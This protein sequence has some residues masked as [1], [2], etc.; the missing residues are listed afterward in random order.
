MFC[1]S[2]LLDKKSV[3]AL[4]ILLVSLNLPC[5]AWQEAKETTEP[6][7]RVSKLNTDNAA[8]KET[9]AS[10]NP[11]PLADTGAPVEKEAKNTIAPVSPVTVHE[12]HPLDQAL[13]MAHDGLKHM[14]ENIH[15]Y[16]ALFVKRE[17]INNQ[18]NDP[19]YMQIKVRN[20]RNTSAGCVPFS[21]YM[22]FVKPREVA[23]REVIWVQGCNNGNLIAHE[24][25]GVI[26]MKTFCLD[27]NGWI[28]MKDN[29]YPIYDAGLENLILK[30]I[31]KAERDRSAGHCE[32]EYRQGAKINGR[33]CT[34]VELVHPIRKPPYEFHKAQVFI[35]DE[36]Q[37]P[38]R[39]AAY[40]WP[41]QEGSAPDLLE[42]YTYVN[43]KLN[44]GLTDMDFDPSNP[45]Y[46]FPGR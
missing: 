42:E 21:V 38:V 18:L 3:G 28:A 39:F 24:A 44:V 5:A 22:K 23:G 13:Q 37:I 17:R 8:D 10:V 33:T 19:Q 25:K 6:I 2:Y 29:R 31:E 14:R 34:M 16:N 12:A 27:P 15:D 43:V 30:L 4:T 40:D 41:V 26:G 36:M 11:L 7:F 35:D 46:N 45:E 20:P 9:P 1:T 32:V